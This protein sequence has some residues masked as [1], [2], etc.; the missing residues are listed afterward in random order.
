MRAERLESALGPAIV[1]NPLTRLGHLLQ[2]LI[3]DVGYLV[4]GR[5]RKISDLV[6]GRMRRTR[7]LSRT[8]S[9]DL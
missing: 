1:G 7:G 3:G 5:V 6:L 9:L 4:P 2:E 8:L